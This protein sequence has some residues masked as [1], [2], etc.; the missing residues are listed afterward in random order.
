M[1]SRS[2]ILAKQKLQALNESSRPEEIVAEDEEESDVSEDSQ[3]SSQEHTENS[4]EEN[5]DEEN[6]GGE[7]SDVVNSDEEQSD[8]EALEETGD[9]PED[10]PKLRMWDYNQC[11]SK[12]CSGRKLKRH[13]K[14]KEL[15]KG[16]SFKGIVLSAQATKVLSPADR[17]IV[18]EHGICVIDC[19]WNR[20]SE[21]PM[22]KLLRGGEPR[23]LPYMIA[24]NTCHYGRPFELNCAE[25]VA[26]TLFITGF[27]N[28]AAW[29]L[30]SFKWGHAFFTV[31]EDAL[32]AYSSVKDEAGVLKVQDKVVKRRERKAAR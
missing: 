20:I 14:I 19:S 11:D 9:R 7:T 30:S 28:E 17:S 12:R 6:S 8:E 15:R 21:I 3:P 1:V 4:D 26:A 27:H 13:G 29:L 2:K 32:D 25:A 24:A 23:K 18:V 31:N 5:S 16:Q 10:L 22:K